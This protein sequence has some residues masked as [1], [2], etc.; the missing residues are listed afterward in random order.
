MSLAGGNVLLD[1]A[2]TTGYI[3]VGSAAQRN[4]NIN[5]SGSNTLA[6]IKA[7]F[8]GSYAD[9]TAAGDNGF[10]LERNLTSTKFHVGSGTE[11]IRFDG[12]N[13]DISAA[14]F[15]VTASDVNIAA[16]NS[17]SIDT[18]DFELSSTQKSM[19]LGYDTNSDVGINIVGGDPS[20]IFFGSKTSPP[21][22]L[23]ADDQAGVNEYFLATNNKAFGDTTVGV[24]IGS[25]AGVQKLELYKDANEFFTYSSDNGFDLRTTK[26]DITTGAGLTI[27]GVDGSTA[28]NNKILLGSATSVDA[29]EGIF[30]D[31]GGNFRVGDA[32]SGGSNFLK[33][34]S[35]GSLQIKSDNIDITSTAFELV[36][37]TDDLQI[38]STHKSMSLA[39]QKIVIEGSSTNGSL[40]IGGV[41][42]VTDTTGA[43]KGFYAEGDGDFIA[44]AGANKYIQFNGGDLDVKTDKLQIDASDFEVSSTEASMSLG[45]GKIKLIGASTST[46]T[47]GA[48]SSITLSDDGTDRFIAV[49]KSNFSDLDQ[50]T[51]GFIVGTDNGT[52]K[53]EVA[54]NSSNYISLN[55]S[56]LDIKTSNFNLTGTS[57]TISLGTLANASDVADTSTGF[58]VDSSG[59]VLI[60]AGT[61]NT[62][63]IRAGLS[64]IIMKSSDFFLGDAT[65][66]ISGSGGNMNIKS[67]NFELDAGNLE[68]SSANVSMSLGE[69]KIRLVGGSTSTITVADNFKISSDGTDEFLAIGSKTS[70]THFD[71]STAGVIMGVD[72]TTT[73]FEVVGNSS[74]YLSFNGTAFDIKSQTFDLNAT[75]III[76]SSG[77]S[78]AGVIRL[79]GSGGPSTPTED[80]AGIYMDGGGALNVYGDASNYLRFDGGSV[81]IRTDEI[82]IQTAGTNKLKLSA[83]GSNTPTFAMGATLN[84]SVAGTNK[85]IFMN[86]EGD[87]LLRGNAS[88]FFKFDASGNTIEIKSDTFDL[89]ASTI[90]MDSAGTGKIALGASPPSDHTSGTGFYVDGDG[91]LLLGSTGGSFIQYA[92]SSGHITIN[93]QIFNLFTSTLVIDSSTNN[94]K[95]ALGAT[96]NSSVGGTNKGVYMD[97][98]GD[99]LV[100][101]DADNF[102]KFDAGGNTLE[103][104]SDTFD[105]A[106]NNLV[107]DSGTNS[108][109]IALGSS[110]PSDYNSG[111]G[112]YA[113]GAGNFKI[114]NSEANNINFDGTDLQISSS[115]FLSGSMTVGTAESQSAQPN[116]FI[117]V[118]KPSS[119]TDN[120]SGVEVRKDYF[121]TYTL[122]GGEIHACLDAKSNSCTGVDDTCTRE[123][124][125]NNLR[126]VVGCVAKPSYADTAGK[127]FL[128]TSYEVHKEA[129]VL[130]TRLVSTAAT[131]ADGLP[132]GTFDYQ[133][134]IYGSAWGG[135]VGL[136]AEGSANNESGYIAI[137]SG[138]M[139]EI[140]YVTAQVPSPLHSNVGAPVTDSQM[141]EMGGLIFWGSS[142][143]IDG[144]GD[145]NCAYITAAFPSGQAGN[146]SVAGFGTTGN[147]DMTHGSGTS[148]RAKGLSVFG[149][150]VTTVIRDCFNRGI[151]YENKANTPDKNPEDYVE[152]E[153]SSGKSPGDL[154]NDW[155]TGYPLIYVPLPMYQPHGDYPGTSVAQVN[156]NWAK[157]SRKIVAFDSTPVVT[158]MIMVG[159]GGKILAIDKDEVGAAAGVGYKIYSEFQTEREGGVA[160][161]ESIPST[162]A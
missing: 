102:L 97:G 95:I 51:A 148:L 107:I 1:G 10:I 25:D 6:V 26:L 77:D 30:M 35:G 105:L 154:C 38:S 23:V 76:D 47:V 92:A 54:V 19:S 49:G 157:S 32:T 111:T 156:D 41:S 7:G 138:L 145:Q 104:K 113:D 126:Y 50:S 82:L 43:N 64:S 136:K 96:P 160:G 161:Y 146:Y 46:I 117:S 45:E 3:R 78:G 159:K 109:K 8:T 139:T 155:S 53:F 21:L 74:N 129:T 73:K 81:D 124:Y 67:V 140:A 72:D 70:F 143:S 144:V 69:G 91:N 29:G 153:S 83:D 86:G 80:V 79:G 24:I 57:G 114:G 48:A 9:G 42:S 20:T 116:S 22:K 106:T 84:T 110:P 149:Y 13:I 61:A 89:D 52:P 93:S 4:N 133:S 151:F 33:F 59:N 28:A 15:S 75:S 141:K 27:S 60:K 150:N 17:I 99:F 71:Q 112:F 152:A 58:H 115:L 100:R 44:K 90:V 40:K 130:F 68:I 34:T 2:Q 5:I 62:G 12:T 66:H 142:V 147:R 94:G 85:G 103:I 88:N 121:A 134:S 39:G 16:G 137:G 14:N 118:G 125:G 132:D 65:N 98:T 55:G 123:E 37:N 122:T 158:P 131:T 162:F 11:Y 108:G 128:R 101:G 135:H 36:A 31:G 127:P 56:N 87:F 119:P 120:T 18:P 63:Y